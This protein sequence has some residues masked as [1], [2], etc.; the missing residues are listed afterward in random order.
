MDAFPSYVWILRLTAVV[1][2]PAAT[3]LALYRSA[4]AAGAGRRAATTLAGGLATGWASWLLL[5]G[6]LAAHRLYAGPANPWFLGAVAAALTAPLLATRIPAVRRALADPGTPARLALPHTIRI[7]GV[8]FLLQAALGQLPAAFAV[9][10]GAGDLA[11]GIAAPF[12]YRRL[13]SGGG[14]RAAVRFNLLGILDLV[15]AA[16]LAALITYRVLEVTPSVESLR[17]FPLA[18]V[19]T[20]T[21]P[22]A[23]ALHI[24]SLRLLRTSAPEPA[25]ATRRSDH[26]PVAGQGA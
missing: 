1:G 6:S 9:P 14:R 22:L 17:L 4:V 16:S 26:R 23:V 25:P 12:V 19:T 2:I 18:L 24:V 11:I 13:V 3:S 8:T 5:T 20:A 7:L 10:A 15:V 21:V